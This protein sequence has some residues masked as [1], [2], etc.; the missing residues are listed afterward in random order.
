MLNRINTQIDQGQF[1]TS[2]AEI[3]TLLCDDTLNEKQKAQ[4]SFELERMVR[5]E[6]DFISSFADIKSYLKKYATD[7]TDEQIAKWDESGELEFRIIDGK[8]R[9]FKNAGYNLF[10]LNDDALSLREGYT[11]FIDRGPLYKIN[12]HHVDIV[13]DTLKTKSAFAQS[14]QITIKYTLTVDANAVPAGELIR[15]WLPFPREIK[16]R[17]TNIKLTASSHQNPIIASNDNLQRTIYMQAK[18]QEGIAE[19]FWVE[20]SYETNGVSHNIDANN[21]KPFTNIPDHLQ[22]YVTEQLPHIEFTP[23]LKQLNKRLIGDETNPYKIAQKLFQYVDSK[24]WGTSIE[25]STIRN[26][27]QHALAAPYADCGQQTMLLI[28]LLRMNGIPA[29][30]QSGWEFSAGAFNTMHDWG[31]VYF[32]PYGWVPMDVTHGILDSSDE[33]L[34]WFYLG[35]LDSYRLIFNDDYSQ[36]LYPAKQHFRSETVDS[37]RGEVEWSGGNVYFDQWDYDMQW[38]VTPIQSSFSLSDLGTEQV[39]LVITDNDSAIQG[40]L[41]RFE[42]QNGQWQQQS[43]SHDIVVGRT[44][45][46]WGLGLHPK[47]DGYHKQEGDGKAPAGI[48]NLTSSFG[49]L[50]NISTKLDYQQMSSDNFCMDVRGSQFYNQ[51][52]DRSVVGEEAIKGSSEPMRRDIHSKDHLY[53][54]GIFVAHNPKNI[55]DQGSCI[56][57]HLWRGETKPTAGCTAMDEFNMDQLLSWLDKS[58]KPVMVALTQVDY[59]RL[60]KEWELP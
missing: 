2:K 6:K 47:Q 48:F 1:S 59:E 8:R 3:I 9:Y 35:G 10:Q 40:R 34:K 31:M 13:N 27:S 42:K 14:N 15:V 44:G 55:S 50:D 4:L 60:K 11:R 16:D 20:Y 25:Y 5:I 56:F 26:L 22:Q 32:E 17:Q 36:P 23:E 21:V 28:T 7:V 37:Q 45:L 38:Q 51:T 29:K 52:V 30:W 33:R 24:K 53:K 58:K 46:A 18:A 41:T 12:Q 49:Y 39:V 54:K 19:Q 43:E 57:V